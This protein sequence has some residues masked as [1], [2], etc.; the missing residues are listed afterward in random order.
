MFPLDCMNFNVLCVK[1]QSYNFPFD[2]R[3]IDCGQIL[4]FSDHG[5]LIYICPLGCRFKGGKS[6]RDKFPRIQWVQ[7]LI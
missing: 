1:Q 4:T 2:L 7:G 5:P 3:K 6:P